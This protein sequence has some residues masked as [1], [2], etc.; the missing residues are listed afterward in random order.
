MGI[1]RSHHKDSYEQPVQCNVTRVLNVAEKIAVFQHRFTVT[2]Y[3]ILQCVGR[4]EQ[5]LNYLPI[6][7]HL[8]LYVLIIAG[9]QDTQFLSWGRYGVKIQL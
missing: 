8:N 3:N 6:Y 1:I 5:R 7:N 4:R 2:F 9:L